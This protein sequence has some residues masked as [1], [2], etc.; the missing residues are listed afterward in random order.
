[1]EPRLHAI[2]ESD[3]GR[4]AV[5]T[6]CGMDGLH[7]AG[8]AQLYDHDGGHFAVTLERAEATCQRCIRA[9]QGF[10]RLDRPLADWQRTGQRPLRHPRRSRPRS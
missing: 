9:L 1:M 8:V 4:Q 10:A 7:A 5:R 6:Y 3:S 2:H